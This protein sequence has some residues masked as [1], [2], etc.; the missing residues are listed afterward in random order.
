MA[1]HSMDEGGKTFSCSFVDLAVARNKEVVR[2][3]FG[4]IS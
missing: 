3:R 2:G 4:I 1:G